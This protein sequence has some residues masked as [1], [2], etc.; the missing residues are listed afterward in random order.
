MSV[1]HS[2]GSY[3]PPELKQTDWSLCTKHYRQFPQS[4]VHHILLGVND[5][6]IYTDIKPDLLIPVNVC[7][8]AIKMIIIKKKKRLAN[9]ILKGQLCLDVSF[10]LQELSVSR[11][12]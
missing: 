7:G 11:S 2:P 10:L 4:F 9:Q 12:S 3:L 1:S 8:S 5:A 6:H